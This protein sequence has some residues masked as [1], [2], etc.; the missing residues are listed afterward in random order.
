MH[1]CYAVG[2]ESNVQVVDPRSG[3]LAKVFDAVEEKA[4]I[5]SLSY[6]QHI[7]TVGGGSGTIS[8][9]E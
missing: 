8:F 1:G 4:G 6:N 5:R 2:S 3:T 9:R 7:L